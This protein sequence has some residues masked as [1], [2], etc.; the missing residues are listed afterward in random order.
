VY[1]HI[2]DYYYIRFFFSLATEKN[3]S[4]HKRMHHQFGLM[5]AQLCVR[6][7]G[8]LLDDI[9]G[10]NLH[11][12]PRRLT[13]K[14]HLCMNIYMQCNAYVMYTTSFVRLV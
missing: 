12:P 8:T 11:F 1:V 7:T 10:R 13:L 9:D 4:A 3:L 2:E 14:L 5:D 6:C